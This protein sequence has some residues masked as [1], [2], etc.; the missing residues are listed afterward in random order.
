MG[1]GRFDLNGFWGSNVLCKHI[2]NYGSDL[3][4]ANMGPYKSLSLESS[5]IP[6]ILWNTLQVLP[7]LKNN[8]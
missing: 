1:H 6:N 4:L 7:E 5:Q 2:D 3:T 8:I